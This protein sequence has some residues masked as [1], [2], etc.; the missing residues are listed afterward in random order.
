M[1]TNKPNTAP[2]SRASQDKKPRRA[3]VAVASIA[4][5]LVLLGG[6][7]G[8]GYLV[9][10]RGADGPATTAPSPSVPAPTATRAPVT[11]REVLGEDPGVWRE[12][13]VGTVTVPGPMRVLGLDERNRL[14]SAAFNAGSNTEPA[15]VAEWL[16]AANPEFTWRSSS[17]GPSLR[18]TGLMRGRLLPTT[19]DL[20]PTEAGILVRVL[21]P[22]HKPLRYPR[23]NDTP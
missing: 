15:T 4:G 6:A 11:D 20:V 22:Q 13:L 19:V 17:E 21:D 3:L 1:A 9:T 16:Q 8:A 7:A 23:G 12:N 14:V 18:L 2:T 10:Q 5:T